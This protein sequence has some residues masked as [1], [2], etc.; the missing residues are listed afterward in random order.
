V[1]IL[2][3]VPTYA[4]AWRYGGPIHAIHGLC[5]SLAEAGHEVAV[6]T[7]SVDGS[8]DLD[9]PLGRSV[10]RDGVAVTYFPC[11]RFRRLY[12]AATL[13]AALHDHA[14][15][16]DIIHT[17]SVFLWPTWAAASAAHRV[18]RPYVLSP[19]GMLVPELIRT[20]SALLKRL[21]IKAIERR[22]LARAAVIHVTSMVEAN[23]LSRARLAL[24]PV[25]VVPNGADLPA[26][27]SLTRRSRTIVY[28]GRLS[29]KKNVA[30]LIDALALLTGTTLVIAGP[31]DE[32]LMPSLRARAQALGIGQRVTFRGPLDA[33]DKSSLLFESA[34][35][36]L[37]S[38]NE[39]FG[40]VVIEAMAHACPVVVT[41][42]V[43][44]R[45]VVEKSGAGAIARD[46][47]APALAVAIAGIL[48]EP[49]AAH[50]AGARGREYVAVHLNWRAVGEQMTAVYEEAV[51]RHAPAH[52]A[53]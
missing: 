1:R 29:W 9:V 34:C 23:H 4:P 50:A 19:R 24:A 18:R 53:R 27:A 3:V 49:A 15:D 51:E 38:L 35:L 14:A 7:T 28:L 52:H 22:N 44:A 25:R 39:N 6:Y 32:N 20:K 12:R 21:W 11:P 48:D 13:G 26:A 47:S 10:N 33:A 40:N 5:R 36:V 37:P 16:F 2:H 17:H 42:D 31:D 45:E 41:P 46:T 43:G 30:T 8:G